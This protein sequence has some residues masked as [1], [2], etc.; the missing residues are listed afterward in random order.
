VAFRY[1]L[2]RLESRT[3]LTVIH[4]LERPPANWTGEAGFVNR[5]ILSRHLP[6]GYRR[7]QFFICGPAPMMDAAESAVLELGVPGQRVHTERF[8]MA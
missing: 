1:E 5:E 4:V 3:N 8:D 7:F 6:H 2:E